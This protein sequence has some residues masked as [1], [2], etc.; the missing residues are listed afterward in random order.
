M[1]ANLLAFDSPK[2]E[3]FLTGLKQQLIK[4]L[5]CSLEISQ[6]AYNLYFIFDKHPTFS[7]NLS[8]SQIYTLSTLV[9]NLTSLYPSLA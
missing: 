5:T 8:H 7:D 4:L 6:S 9:V 2:T 1:T 3:F